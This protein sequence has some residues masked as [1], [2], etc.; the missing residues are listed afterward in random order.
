MFISIPEQLVAFLLHF[1]VCKQVVVTFPLGLPNPLLQANTQF[2]PYVFPQES[3]RSNTLGG[4]FK[5][6]HVTALK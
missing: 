6:G 2:D 3:F 5:G 1:P 4:I